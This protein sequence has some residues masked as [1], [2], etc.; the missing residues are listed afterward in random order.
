MTLDDGSYHPVDSSDLAF[1]IAGSMA[2]KKAFLDARPIL[3]EPIYEVE[4]LVPEEFM[5]DV[6]GDISSRRGKILGME[7]EGGNQKVRALIPLAELHKYSTVLRSMTQGRGIH[8]RKLSHYEEVPRE[9]TEKIVVASA[10]QQKEEG[11]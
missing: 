9:I 11:E 1:K 4:I 6:L 7:S 5:G 3:L 2:F 8:R 10:K